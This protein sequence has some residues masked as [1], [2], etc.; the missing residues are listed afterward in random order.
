MFC[1][2]VD[3]VEGPVGVVAGFWA[4]KRARGERRG[5]ESALERLGK[6]RV[7]E[8]RWKL[9]EASDCSG[10]SHGAGGLSKQTLRAIRR[11]GLLQEG[12][13]VQAEAEAEEAE[14]AAERE[15]LLQ[16]GVQLLGLFVLRPSYPYGEV[17]GRIVATQNAQTR[18]TDEHE[19]QAQLTRLRELAPHWFH[20]S[21][22][23]SLG[24]TI[25]KTSPAFTLPAL[26]LLV[27]H[28]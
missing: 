17:I 21:S 15:Q 11:R 18:F 25:S 10:E 8:L 19:V 20:I 9:S 12:E 13:R 27:A 28:A 2:L 7:Q 6:S 5:L 3:K 22:H 14:R 4:E 24:L 26:K 16:V 23:K 1:S